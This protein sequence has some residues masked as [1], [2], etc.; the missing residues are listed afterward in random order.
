MSR[1]EAL[2][3]L[4]GSKVGTFLVRFSDSEGCFAI[5]CLEEEDRV[6]HQRVIRQVD[7]NGSYLCLSFSSAYCGLQF[8]DLSELIQ[9]PKISEEL[10]LKQPFSQDSKFK[11]IK[12]H[13]LYSTGDST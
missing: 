2:E 8:Q 6:H 11:N 9:N 5:S 1:H 13:D 12:I 3:Y 10:D 4:K 7:E